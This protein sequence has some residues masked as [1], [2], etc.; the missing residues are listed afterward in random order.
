MPMRQ[1]TP[2]QLDAY[3]RETPTPPLLLDVR[4]PWEYEIAHIEG[5]TL[6]PLRQVP[7]L[8][9]REDPERE[10]V[11]ICHHGIRS[12]HAGLFLEHHGF[13]RIINLAGGIDAWARQV[14]TDLP[15]Y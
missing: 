10:I 1:F 6:V 4:E 5:S 12:H 14:D 2:A 8:V 3:L 13:R 15:V 7:E 11:V 9:N